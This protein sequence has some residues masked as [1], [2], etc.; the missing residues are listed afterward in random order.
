MKRY[1]REASLLLPA[2]SCGLLSDLRALIR[3]QGLGPR[4]AA[5]GSQSFRGG[6]F[7]VINDGFLFIANGK[8]RDLYRV[9][10]YVRWALLSAWAFRHQSPNYALGTHAV[11]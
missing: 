9:A 6:V 1:M 5:L 10:Y 8:P 2:F 11:K 3:S 7:A 4:G